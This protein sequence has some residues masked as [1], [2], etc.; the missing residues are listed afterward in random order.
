MTQIEQIRDIIVNTLKVGD[1]ISTSEIAR[2]TGIPRPSVRRVL[3]QLVSDG[4]IRRVEPGLF[5]RVDSTRLGG[6]V[7]GTYR[8]KFV[9]GLFYC[10]GKKRQFFATTFEIDNISREEELI[11][12]LENGIASNCSELRENHGYSDEPGF[13]DRESFPRYPNIEG[14]EL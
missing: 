12:F 4:E 7:D 13:E 2:S 3:S 1:L 8:R 10:G 6:Q 9:S 14:G 11:R 5:S